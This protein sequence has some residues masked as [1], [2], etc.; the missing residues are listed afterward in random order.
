MN[1]RPGRA[2]ARSVARVLLAAV[3]ATA[4]VLAAPV[5]AAPTTVATLAQPA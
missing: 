4:P 2:P 5:L 3:L 1:P